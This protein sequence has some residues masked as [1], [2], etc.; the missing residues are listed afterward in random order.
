MDADYLEG[1]ARPRLQ[2]ELEVFEGV[3]A[4][5]WETNAEEALWNE[6]AAIRSADK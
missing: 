4:V 5:G 6:I 1:I 3:P 2:A